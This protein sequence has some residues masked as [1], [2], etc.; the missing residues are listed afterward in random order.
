MRHVQRR[1]GIAAVGAGTPTASLPQLSETGVFN[2]RPKQIP[3]GD[4][5]DRTVLVRFIA[6][7]TSHGGQVA[8]VRVVEGMRGAPL[9][10]ETARP[11]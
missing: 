10:L 9:L 11:K 5:P 6:H 7:L 1:L 3:P 2:V 4:A 8:M